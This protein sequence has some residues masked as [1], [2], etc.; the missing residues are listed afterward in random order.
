M[1]D[2]TGGAIAH[3]AGDVFVDKEGEYYIANQ[4][5]VHWSAQDVANLEDGF[6]IFLQTG[7]CTSAHEAV[8]PED[9]QKVQQFLAAKEQEKQAYADKWAWLKEGK[10]TFTVGERVQYKHTGVFGIVKE[11]DNSSGSLRVQKEASREKPLWS[12]PGTVKHV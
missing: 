3:K 1:A 9:L 6:D 11:I 10:G 5:S 2:F 7:Y 8:S 4:D 12:E